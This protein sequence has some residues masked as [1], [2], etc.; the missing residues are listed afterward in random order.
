MLLRALGGRGDEHLGRGDDLVA[1]RVVLADPGLVEAEV[2][3]VL[4]QLEVAV[5]REVRVLVDGVERGEE[6]PATHARSPFVSGWAL[7]DSLPVT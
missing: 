6:D 1:G 7:C 4:D 5:D 3:E 2:V